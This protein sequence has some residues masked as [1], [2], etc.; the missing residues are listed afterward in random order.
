MLP[1]DPYVG[2]NTTTPRPILPKVIFGIPAPGRWGL[3]TT[4]GCVKTAMTSDIPYQTMTGAIV[5]SK[6]A[7]REHYGIGPVL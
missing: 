7:L 3:T 2:A 4:G 1:P 6:E 5:Q